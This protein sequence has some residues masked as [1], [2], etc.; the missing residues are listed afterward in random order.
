MNFI[1]SGLQNKINRKVYYQRKNQL[2][3]EQKKN[4][5]IRSFL[6][7]LWIVFCFTFFFAL[8]FFKSYFFHFD[9]WLN[10]FLN[11]LIIIFGLI[12]CFAL[13]IFIIIKID[14]KFPY[15][16]LPEISKKALEACVLPLKDYY[17]F[18]KPFI[19]TKCY[20]STNE[21]FINKDVILFVCENKLRIIN[22]LT[23]SSLDIGCYEFCIE[24]LDYYYE[25]H[26]NLISCVLKCEQ[27]T[28]RLAKTAI[29]FIKRNLLN[30]SR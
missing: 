1:R 3:K 6:I 20:D 23:R 9:G 21:D 8:C 10:S 12:G 22:D 15:F 7:T 28:F 18:N 30:N 29:P 16:P 4:N 5:L 14:K 11:V 2:T 17:A 13:L 25:P 27:T 26:N 19:I 24:E